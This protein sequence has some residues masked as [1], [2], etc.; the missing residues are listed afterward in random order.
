MDDPRR[1]LS[2]EFK[3]TLCERDADRVIDVGVCRRVTFQRLD[4]LVPCETDTPY[5]LDDPTP[6]ARDEDGSYLLTKRYLV[7]VPSR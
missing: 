3:G 7:M 6:C 2:L 1:G 5:S 4:G